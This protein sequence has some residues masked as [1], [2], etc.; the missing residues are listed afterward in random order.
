TLNADPFDTGMN[1]L[2]ADPFST[3][4]GTLNADPF[5]TG[6]GTSNDPF[7]RGMNTLDALFGEM[8]DAQI[9]GSFD[10]TAMDL[11]TQDTHVPFDQAMPDLT[12]QDFISGQWTAPLTD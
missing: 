12:S 8:H 7:G 5:S 4:M 11:F 3:G 10:D 2:N 9:G 6:M 1:T